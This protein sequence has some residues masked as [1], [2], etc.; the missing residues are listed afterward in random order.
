MSYTFYGKRM[1][2]KIGLDNTN[3]IADR[4]T[5][6][7]NTIEHETTSEVSTTIGKSINEVVENE[8]IEEEKIAVNTSAIENKV[9]EERREETKEKEPEI[10]PDPVFIKPVDGEIL[11]E[12]FK[13]NLIYSDTLEEWTTHLGIDYEAEKTS[14]VKASAGG[15]IRSIKNDPRYGLTVVIEH[16]NG[17]SSLYANLLSTEFIEVGEEVEAGQTIATVGNTAAFEIADPTHLHFEIL[18]DGES[19]DPNL[20]LE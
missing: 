11:K 19:V 15:V 12:Y 17:F 1:D 13:D 7:L 20:Y 14:I 3:T 16:S 4:T 9:I 18:I 6:M 2:K 10:I 8:Q 5:N